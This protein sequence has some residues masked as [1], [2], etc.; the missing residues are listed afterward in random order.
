M[1]QID[2]SLYV[3]VGVTGHR[4]IEISM[5]NH[6]CHVI[7]HILLTIRTEVESVYQS[8]S[9]FF[10]SIGGG[11]VPKMRM[12]SSLAEGADRIAVEEAVSLGY[13]LQVPLPL[14]QLRYEQT[15]DGGRASILEFR[16][17]L[18]KA[19]AVT[20]LEFTKQESSSA[21]EDA[22]RLMLY[23]SDVLIA[24]WNGKPNKYIAGTYPTMR[25]AKRLH[26]PIIC[27]SSENPETIAF[28]QESRYRTDW[29]QAL[30]EHISRIMLPAD[31]VSN[32][33]AG[34]VG[35]P[36]PPR[37]KKEQIRNYYDLNIIIEQCLQ[38]GMKHASITEDILNHPYGA[39]TERVLQQKARAQKLWGEEKKLYSGLSR[40]YSVAFRN[41]VLLRF[42]VPLVALILLLGALNTDGVL[43][44]VLY[45]LQICMLI[46]VI[47]LVKREKSTYTNRCFYG[48]RV[49]AERIRIST[50]LTNIGYCNVN[51]S[52]SSYMESKFLSESMWYYRILL[53][54]RGLQNLI[55]D[56]SEIKAWLHWLQK[57][58]LCSQL[59]Y[60][61]KRKEK[62]FELQ[63]KLGK[64][65][66]FSFYA[67]LLFTVVRA[68][69]DMLD[70]ASY[71]GYAGALALFLPS[72]ATFWTSYSGSFGYTQHYA[73]SSAM[74]SELRS[75]I[76]EVDALLMEY[77]GEE[78]IFPLT[79]K[80]LC[81]LYDLCERLETCCTTELSD[82][83]NSIHGRMLKLV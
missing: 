47:W 56:D 70:F 72:L 3:N 18:S 10:E 77:E 29:E 61:H 44:S 25:E 59:H 30:R 64:L 42:S 35:I 34:F 26:V 50:F 22:S 5:Q 32:M 20:S 24:V 17:L 62:C 55:L 31:N 45:A 53:R 15:F 40:A 73:A 9:T 68:C 69:V 58:F 28:I 51:R 37:V 48:Y 23:H 57:D 33:S 71:L 81:P 12:V 63:R 60:H 83:E 41:S 52:S 74:E 27:I 8:K 6:L 78:K 82:W 16:R 4:N 21:Y 36:F 65:A 54:Y 66:V 1:K 19:T 67:G 14:G 13:E 49:M 79:K 38:K 75:I 11:D 39:N 7:K 76:A 46:F 2:K 80:G 43:E